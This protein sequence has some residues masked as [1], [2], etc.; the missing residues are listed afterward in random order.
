[1]E[2]QGFSDYLI[3]PDGRVWSKKRGGRWIKHTR[4]G[5]NYIGCTLQNNEKKQINKYITETLEI[6]SPSEI[7]TRRYLYVLD[8]IPYVPDNILYISVSMVD[9]LV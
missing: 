1:M 5:Y 4:R 2:I 8:I 7:V 9:I 3:Y 6:C